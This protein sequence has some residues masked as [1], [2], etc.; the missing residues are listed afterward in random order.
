MLN[1]LELIQKNRLSELLLQ[2]NFGLEKENV[3]T[4]L[5]GKLAL[6]EHPAVLGDKTI[7]P[8]ITTDFAESQIEMVTP[9]MSSPRATL[10]FMETLHDLVSLELKDEILWPYSLPPILPKDSSL[11]KEA[12]FKNPEITEYREYLSNKYGKSKQLLSGVHYNFSF[13]DKFLELLYNADH[14]NLSFRE[15]KDR[16]YLKLARYYLKYSWLTIYLFGGNSVA[17]ESYI[18]CCRCDK[19]K[20]TDDTYVFRGAS[21]FRNGVSGYRNIEHFNVS[22]NS[23]YDYIDSIKEA[24][25]NGYIIA[26]K[27]YYSQIRLKGSNKGKVL[28]DLHDFGI[29]Y[30]EIRTLDLNPLLKVGISLESLEFMHL[31]FIYALIAPNFSTRPEEYLLSNQNQI[32]A[33]DFNR[34]KGINLHYTANET[35]DLREWGSDV[36]DNMRILLK[37]VGVPIDKLKVLDKLQN[38]LKNNAR[39]IA[40][41][42]A[43]DVKEQG[44]VNFFLDKAKNY[45]KMSRETAYKFIGFE[46]L[47]LS[48]QILLK[49]AVKYGLKYKF[50]DRKDNFIELSNGIISQIIRQATKTTIDNYAA[51]SIMENKQVTKELI[52]RNGIVVAHGESYHDIE[53][54]LIDYPLFMEKAVVIKPNST[55]FGIGITIFKGKFSKEDYHK[56]LEL[57]FVYDKQVLVEDFI[58]GREFRFFVIDDKSVAILQ[59]DPA[60]VIGDGIKNIRELV[61]IKNQSPLR[62]IGYKTPLEK[63]KLGIVEE[64]FLKTQGL[65][66]DSVIAQNKKIYLRENSNIST[67]GDS[68]DFTDVVPN[69]YKRIAVEAAKSV[70]ARICGVDMIIKNINNPYPDNNYAILELNFNPALHI[71]TYPY[72]GQDR[73]VSE[74]ILHL[75]DLL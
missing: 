66:F 51:I 45:L 18:D 64:D 6:T 5:E 26:D 31:M 61:E 29:H 10:D 65:N 54:A 34:N 43:H 14:S 25:N 7:H 70:G 37:E 71:H 53:S 15:Y 32:L 41:E 24:I 27:E 22:Y 48:T 20:L 36:I 1:Y 60:N 3:R 19:E 9:P 4:T 74:K 23:L 39:S 59:R 12:Q 33:A 58:T 42:I 69:S 55:N 13:S 21:S 11:I 38:D 35:R 49:D 56:A 28:Q 52:S 75:L 72:Q 50:L 73:K 16:V 2:G 8:Y 40:D 30:I 68:L 63:I 57:A 44:Y 67:G 46:D 62:G 47:E 17:H